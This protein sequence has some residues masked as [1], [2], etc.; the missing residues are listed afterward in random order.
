[1]PLITILVEDS[2]TIREALIP[3]ML[4][5]GN[6]EVVAF[7]ETPDEASVAFEN[8]KDEWQVAVV[9][10]FL[11]QGT[12]LAV[13]RRLRDRD[14]GRHV[15]VLTNY[16]TDALREQCMA[17]GA[18]AMFDKSTELDPFFDYCKALG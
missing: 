17:L 9:D 15:V 14:P 12:G 5:L 7:A 8:F 11:K 1:M 13:L 4:E 2:P 16:C 3:S 18:N 6:M 10:L